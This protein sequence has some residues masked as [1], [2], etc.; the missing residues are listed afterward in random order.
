MALPSQLLWS[1]ALWVEDLLISNILHSRSWLYSFDIPSSHEN[2]LDAIPRWAISD[3]Q[4][5]HRENKF[6]QYDHTLQLLFGSVVQA[7]TN[8]AVLV[9]FHS[10]VALYFLECQVSILEKRMP[11]SLNGWRE[12]RPSRA[13]SRSKTFPKV[14][15]NV[16][17]I[18]RQSSIAARH[19]SGTRNSRGWLGTWVAPELF[20]VSGS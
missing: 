1:S 9:S 2:C 5:Y 4:S 19:G 14:P 7:L 10:R 11:N 16:P 8:S 17:C 15:T 3:N 13:S 18:V 20:A 6:H 12:V